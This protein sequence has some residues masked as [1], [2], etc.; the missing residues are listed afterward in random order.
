MSCIIRFLLS[1][2]LGAF[3]QQ[4]FIA[5]FNLFSMSVPSNSQSKLSAIM[6]R[7]LFCATA[8]SKY[9]NTYYMLLIFWDVKRMRGCSS[10]HRLFLMSVIKYGDIQPLSILRP[11]TNSILCYNV[12]PSSTVIAPLCPTFSKRRAINFPIFTSLFEDI[13]AI[14]SIYSFVITFYVRASIS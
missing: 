5:P 10:S 6:T 7:G 11:S 3:M 13:V 2:Q 1:P 14:F 4:T 9:L 12:F 8:N